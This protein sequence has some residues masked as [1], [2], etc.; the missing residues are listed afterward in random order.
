MSLMPPFDPRKKLDKLYNLTDSAL[1]AWLVVSTKQKNRD[2]SDEDW[3]RL[4]KCTKG[5]EE[6]IQ[7]LTNDLRAYKEYNLIATVFELREACDF[8][9]QKSN[10][11][12]VLQEGMELLRTLEVFKHFTAESPDA[13]KAHDFCQRLSDVHNSSFQYTDPHELQWE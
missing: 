11:L 2:V 1:D 7:Y 12:K 4:G 8:K 10:V 6:L 9:E 3:K 5:L 13:T